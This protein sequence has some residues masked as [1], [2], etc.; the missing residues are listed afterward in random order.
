M[1][2]SN[3]FFQFLNSLLLFFLKMLLMVLLRLG[4]F[5]EML[6]LEFALYVLDITTSLDLFHFVWDFY[7]FL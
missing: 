7:F 5:E 6:Y 2:T 3:I 4:G 1:T